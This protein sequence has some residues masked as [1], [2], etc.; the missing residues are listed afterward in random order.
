MIEQRPSLELVLFVSSTTGAT[1]LIVDQVHVF[2]ARAGIEQFALDVVDVA[3]EPDRA[4]ADRI[5][6]TPTLL[7]RAPTPVRRVIGSF[8]DH[9]RTAEALGMAWADAVAGE[10]PGDE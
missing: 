2:L 10:G 9:R 8:G 1:D 5:L 7:K 3:Q 6:A 4:E